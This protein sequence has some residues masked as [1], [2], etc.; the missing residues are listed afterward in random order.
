MVNFKPNMNIIDRIAR[1]IVGSA[2]IFLGPVSEIV[3]TDEVSTFILGAV[4]AI[5]LISSF[6][7]YC[8]LYEMTGFNTLKRP[9]DQDSP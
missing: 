4:G 3:T 9:K 2:L 8:I 5:A 7:S 6:F 1:A